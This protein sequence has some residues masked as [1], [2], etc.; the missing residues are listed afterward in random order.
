[1]TGGG[2]SPNLI[3]RL[4]ARYRTL[5]HFH[6]ISEVGEITRRY[7][8]MN[9]FDGVLT[10]LG[11]L[12]GA[13]LGGVDEARA[14][15][16][17]IV[18][19]AVAMGVSGA[20]GSYMVESAERGRALRELEESTLSSLADTTIGAAS[21]YA[22]VVVSA[23]TGGAPFVAG[24]VA[25]APF[26]LTAFWSVDTA[27]YLAVAVAFAELSLL[28]AFLGRVSKDRVL[29]YALRLVAGGILALGLS[30]AL[31]AGVG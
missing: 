10:T 4:R 9:G 27:Y 2:A 25:A 31:G 26:L 15:V 22:S 3:A 13:Y 14:V 19:T 21:R 28:G 24:S 30:L 6:E 8:A 7:F 1:M 20:Y 18:T 23:V 12:A 11:V 17:L 16:V 29:G 5:R